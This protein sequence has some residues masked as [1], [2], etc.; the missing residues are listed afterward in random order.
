MG[1]FRNFAVNTVAGHPVA[2]VEQVEVRRVLV[3]SWSTYTYSW[4]TYTYSWST[5]TYSWST[6][7]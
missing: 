5:Y 3:D 1:V 4:S 6:Y 2:V 7:T